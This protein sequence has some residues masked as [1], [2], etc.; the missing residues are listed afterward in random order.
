MR[1]GL[2]KAEATTMQSKLRQVF[3]RGVHLTNAHQ[4]E[5]SNI[6]SFAAGL[7]HTEGGVCRMQPAEPAASLIVIGGALS[8][9]GHILGQYTYVLPT[10]RD[11]LDAGRRGK[12]RAGAWSLNKTIKGV[13]V[14]PRE[15]TVWGA[16]KAT[17]HG[18]HN[19]LH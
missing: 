18:G 9:Y 16:K 15:V 7:A 10:R 2:E 14:L 12:K 4:G 17:S 1:G 6:K 19:S 13:Y 5:Y 3:E 11:V 8:G